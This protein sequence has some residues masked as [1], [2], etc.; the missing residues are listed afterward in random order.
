MGSEYIGQTLGV[1]KCGQ[2]N[3]LLDNSMNIFSTTITTTTNLTAIDPTPE[4]VQISP[5][6]PKFKLA[7]S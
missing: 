6:M 7:K 5:C 1:G 4:R 3:A 2:N